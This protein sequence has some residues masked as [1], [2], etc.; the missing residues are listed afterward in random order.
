M[1]SSEKYLL[2][3][4][5][6]FALLSLWF[7]FPQCKMTLWQRLIC[8][9]VVWGIN[10]VFFCYDDN[11]IWVKHHQGN[12]AVLCNFVASFAIFGWMAST[13]RGRAFYKA[14]KEFDLNHQQL[15]WGIVVVILLLIPIVVY[16]ILHDI[17]I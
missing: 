5:I 7:F 6:I 3:A 11:D 15:L 2:V 4:D 9:A 1:T 17:L 8:V 16:L 13:E 14:S 12:Y 10:I